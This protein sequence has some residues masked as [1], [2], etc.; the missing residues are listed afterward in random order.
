MQLGWLILA[1]NHTYWIS[2]YNRSIKS[3]NIARAS[4]IV[5]QGNGF[6]CIGDDEPNTFGFIDKASEE[7]VNPILSDFLTMDE[8]SGAKEQC[9]VN[10]YSEKASLTTHIKS[11]S[12]FLWEPLNRIS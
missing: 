6:T 12:S 11:N 4:E 8:R 7:S 2:K 1:N 9:R 10:S 5:M 3:I